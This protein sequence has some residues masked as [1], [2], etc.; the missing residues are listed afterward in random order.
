L[1]LKQGE[2]ICWR[3]ADPDWEDPFDGSYSMRF[4][5]RWNPA[6][7]FPVC[8]LNANEATALANADWMIQ[9]VAGI[10]VDVDDLEVAQLPVIIP[11]LVPGRMVLDVLSDDGCLDVG[12]EVTYPLDASGSFIPHSRCQP[13]GLQAWDDDLDGVA[14]RSAALLTPDGQE[15]AWFDRTGKRLVPSAAPR[16]YT[17]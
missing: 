16:R 4:G 10:G 15:L 6:G 11:C 3:V 8:Y 5:Q 14:C 13:I 12:L 17:P 9:R 7:S 1:K 2:A